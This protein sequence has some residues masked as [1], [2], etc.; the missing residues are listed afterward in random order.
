MD[1]LSQKIGEI[2]S[3]PQALQQL[4]GLGEMLG[5]NNTE[6]ESVKNEVNNDIGSAGNMLSNMMGGTSPDMLS[7]FTKVAPMIS[8]ISK[9]DDTTRLLFA[10][11]PFLSQ[12][13]QKKLDEASKLLKMMKLLPLLKDFNIL[14]SLF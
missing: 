12:K 8:S 14:D 11:R 7:L 4:Q 5:L 3:D 9:E 2:L 1:D 6:K 10:L 13:R